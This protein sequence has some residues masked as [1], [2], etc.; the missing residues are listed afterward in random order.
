MYDRGL[1]TAWI[2]P[3]KSDVARSRQSQIRRSEYATSRRSVDALQLK[4]VLEVSRN[5]LC[6]AQ[7]QLQTM[8]VCRILDP[9]IF[10]LLDPAIQQKL[11]N[12]EVAG[13][14]LPILVYHQTF[15][16]ARIHHVLDDLLSLTRFGGQGFVRIAKGSFLK[17][18]LDPT[19]RDRV[20]ACEHSCF[21]SDRRGG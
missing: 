21:V 11:S 12:V 1:S 3:A 8:L 7:V 4:V 13:L 10:L 18:T 5:L 19:L 15:D 17:H 2:G 20:R 9:L 16:Q 6:C 14:E